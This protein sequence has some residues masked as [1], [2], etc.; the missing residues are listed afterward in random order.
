MRQLLPGVICQ[1]P[2]RPEIFVSISV[3][4]SFFTVIEMQSISCS[5][6]FCIFSGG[7]LFLSPNEKKGP[8]AEQF[9]CVPYFM[10]SE[11][12][13]KWLVFKSYRVRAH[14]RPHFE[15]RL[16]NDICFDQNVNK[17]VACVFFFSAKLSC[18]C[19]DDVH[20]YGSHCR[21]WRESRNIA[22][23][24]PWRFSLFVPF[25]VVI[26]FW[27]IFNSFVFLIETIRYWTF[28]PMQG[29][30][31]KVRYAHLNTSDG[32]GWFEAYQ[33]RLSPAMITKSCF[34]RLIVVF[35][36]IIEF[37]SPFFLDIL[38]ISSE[39]ISISKHTQNWV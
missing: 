37:G 9:A 2:F 29:Q 24:S 39:S 8:I 27:Q 23:N 17:V 28:F 25:S 7:W 13:N 30:W 1:N 36:L 33:Q 31:S 6:P 38:L 14:F 32:V 21:K 34:R 3:N 22:M 11:E 19:V 4:S 35:V 16:Q 26:F 12:K 10:S 5:H 15:N 20:A 18:A